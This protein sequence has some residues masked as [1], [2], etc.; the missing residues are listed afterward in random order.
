[1]SFQP[2]AR[3]FATTFSDFLIGKVAVFLATC[4]FDDVDRFVGVRSVEVSA[5]VLKS[6]IES[7][8]FGKEILD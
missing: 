5:I 6:F 1:V 7:L 2:L 8:T 4:C 3:H